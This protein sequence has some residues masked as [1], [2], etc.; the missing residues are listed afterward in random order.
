M[1]LPECF[2]EGRH[3][4]ARLNHVYYYAGMAAEKAE[5]KDKAIEY[6]EAALPSGRWV[7][8]ATFYQGLAAGK[9]GREMDAKMA[10][11]SLVTEGE[12]LIATGGKYGFFGTGVP[13]PPP[14][15][16]DRE[17]RNVSEGLYLRALGYY[18]LGQKEKARLDLE[19]ALHWNANH[20]G[21]WI[22]LGKSGD[23]VKFIFGR[24]T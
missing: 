5:L 19:S 21:A 4:V 24:N 6:Y 17:K 13:T 23:A 20:L 10:F 12:S 22:H 15:E 7:N 9:L 11:E 8:E 14:F 2:H 3:N 18:G 1:V 16:G